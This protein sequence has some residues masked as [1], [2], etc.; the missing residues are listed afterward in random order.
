MPDHVHFLL[1]VTEHA[2]ISD[3][4]RQYKSG[5]AF[6]IGIGSIWQPRF[7]IRIPKNTTSV[8]HYI[9]QNPVRAKLVERSE[10][11]PWSSASGRW[12]IV[13]VNHL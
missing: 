5:V 9:H 10:D 3:I 4:I 1:Y 13:D 7:H 2:N 6:N 8:L 12:D 11:Y